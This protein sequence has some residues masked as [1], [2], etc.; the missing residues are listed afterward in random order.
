MSILSSLHSYFIISF[1]HQMSYFHSF[2]YVP[3]AQNLL[4]VIPFSFSTGS[5]HL[6]NYSSSRFTFK[7]FSLIP[8]KNLADLFHCPPL[9]ARSELTESLPKFF[10]CLPSTVFKLFF[11]V[12]IIISDLITMSQTVDFFFLIQIK[13]TRVRKVL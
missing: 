10:F 9:Q 1:Y 3:L 12:I 5:L 13:N 11:R 4:C 7:T 2:H 6:A 8:Q